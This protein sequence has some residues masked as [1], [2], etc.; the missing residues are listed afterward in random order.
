VLSEKLLVINTARKVHMMPGRYY[1]PSFY[2]PLSKLLR[3]PSLFYKA[4]QSLFPVNSARSKSLMQESIDRIHGCRIEACLDISFGLVSSPGGRRP[5]VVTL[6]AVEAGSVRG[7]TTMA[8]IVSAVWADNSYG[9]FS[10]F[11]FY[12]RQFDQF[13]QV[14]SPPMHKMEVMLSK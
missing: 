3:H 13:E 11:R 14:L 4:Y 2:K 1:K 7:D 5:A 8:S 9:K 10:P 6:D 12:I